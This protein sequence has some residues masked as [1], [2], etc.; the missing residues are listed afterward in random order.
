MD[1]T[2]P[3]SV[4]IENVQ[5][6]ADRLKALTAGSGKTLTLDASAVEFI[7]TPGIQ[8]LLSTQKN[9]QAAGGALAVANP[10]GVFKQAVAM[11]GLEKEFAGLAA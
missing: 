8:L 2:L 4:T 3:S 10:S 11:L 7:T 1:F 5:E 6:I 9:L